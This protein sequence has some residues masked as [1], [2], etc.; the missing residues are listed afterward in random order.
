MADIVKMMIDGIGDF[1][2]KILDKEREKEI[3]MFTEESNS[4]DLYTILKQYV[5]EG[6]YCEAEDMLFEELNKGYSEG[7]YLAGIEF[8]EMLK[9]IDKDI[10]KAGNF[11]YSE[12]QDGIKA[13]NKAKEE[14]AGFV[15]EELMDNLI[16]ERIVP[17]F[18]KRKKGAKK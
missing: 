8:Y 15:D 9:E 14:R 6:Q 17:N 1:T 16:E 2:A 11:P 13:L 18:P 4:H 10:L 7:K 3:V 12:I 5:E